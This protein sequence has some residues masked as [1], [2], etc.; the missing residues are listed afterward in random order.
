MLSE[1]GMSALVNII[2]MRIVS[3]KSAKHTVLHSTMALPQHQELETGGAQ[4]RCF[5]QEV[6]LTTL[7]CW[8][9]SV[10]GPGPGAVA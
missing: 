5:G 7:E 9:V 6:Q 4:R 1:V 8:V 3:K 2:G 10:G